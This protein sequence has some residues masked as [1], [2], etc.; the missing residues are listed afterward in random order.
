MTTKKFF[1]VTMMAGFLATI[2]LSALVTTNV[3]ADCGEP[4]DLKCVQCHAEQAQYSAADEWHGSHY[5]V[6]SCTNC[7]AGN[8]SSSDKDIAHVS[9]VANPLSDVYSGCHQCHPNDYLTIAEGYALKL[10]I[11]PEACVTPTP[12]PQGVMPVNFI[13]S[14]LNIP[15]AGAGGPSLGVS[16]AWIAGAVLL[17]TFFISG[18]RWLSRHDHGQV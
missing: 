4:Q 17:L 11:T 10:G 16:I 18:L 3:R 15:P 6:A 2:L 12:V 9:L 7:H 14:D 5:K 13:G 1:R 8:A